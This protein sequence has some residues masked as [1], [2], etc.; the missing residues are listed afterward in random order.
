MLQGTKGNEGNNWF[1]DYL[2]A[3][4]GYVEVV[5]MD[6]KL[7]TGNVLYILRK[8]PLCA[9]DIFLFNERR[10]LN[11]ETCN[12]TILESIEDGIAVSPKYNSNI[13]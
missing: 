11:N 4:H 5:R 1:Q 9:T 6:L 2:A 7:K 13:L 8:R 3:L 12:Y 10:A